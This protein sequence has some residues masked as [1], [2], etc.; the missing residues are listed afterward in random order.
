MSCLVS[1]KSHSDGRQNTAIAAI[2]GRTNHP[3]QASIA[4]PR[5]QDK[6][7][8]SIPLLMAFRCSA[9]IC[10]FFACWFD[11]G[12][13]AFKMSI[14]RIPY[15][16]PRSAFVEAIERDGCVIV[17]DFTNNATLEEVRKEVQPCL[18]ANDE[19]SQVGALNGGTKACTKLIG[20]SKTVRES[21]F[22]D[23]LYQVCF[24]IKLFVLL[25]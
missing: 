8:S 7:R 10:I 17:T 15:S 24:S 11:A 9:S 18:D 6:A 14:Q 3:D 2:I 1:V 25:L 22:S 4:D 19:K 12:F 20:R 23:P 21:F 5:S 16:R 13:G